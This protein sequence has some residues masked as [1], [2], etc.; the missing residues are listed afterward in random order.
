MAMAGLRRLAVWVL[1]AGAALPAGAQE[2]GSV[3][4]FACPYVDWWN[5]PTAADCPREEAAREQA[6]MR[7]DRG[8][9]RPTK[10]RAAGAGALGGEHRLGDAAE[11]TGGDEASPRG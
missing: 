5:P 11:G 6:R 2:A 8:P 10:A 3:G 9:G 4:W 1:A 7:R